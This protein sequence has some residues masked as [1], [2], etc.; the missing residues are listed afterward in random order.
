MSR[1]S[2]L[3]FSLM[4]LVVSLAVFSLTAAGFAS[5]LVDNAKL[6]KSQQMA[7][8]AQSDARNCV[9]IIEQALRTAGWDPQNTGFSGITLQS[10]PVA[11]NN[12]IQ[13]RADLDEDAAH[14]ERGRGRDDP[15]ERDHARVEDV[16]ER[17]VR[18]ALPEHHQRRRR[19]RHARADVH[20]GFDDEPDTHHGDDHGS[21][22]G[23]RSPDG[24][25]PPATV[26]TDVVL[27]GRL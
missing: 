20:A 18:D 8:T 21:L 22:R 7:I 17:L 4:E 14:D 5:M 26:S 24:T 11:S 10:P 16:H 13:I 23:A 2:E 19:Q 25:V 3:G 9:T 15:E 27:R 1:S 6:N 12:W